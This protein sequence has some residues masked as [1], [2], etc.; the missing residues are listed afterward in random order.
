MPR[1]IGH[2]VWRIFT[3]LLYILVS[4]LTIFF[5]Y[6]YKYDFQKRD[7]QKTSII[8][9]LGEE[10]G[11]NVLLDGVNKAAVLPVQIN[12]VI[13][14]GHDLSVNKT[15]YLPWQRKVAVDADL[16]S[17]IDDVYL[18]PE[19]VEAKI[20][21]VGELDPESK[22]YKG[23]DFLADV[24]EG[25]KS[26]DMMTLFPEGIPKKESID[27]MQDGLRGLQVFEKGD[28]MLFF[29]K[30]QVAIAN[31]GVG[32]FLKF[33]LPSG[34]EEYRLGH[35]NQIFYF[36]MR[37]DLYAVPYGQVDKL[38]SAPKDFLARKNVSAYAISQD[39][40][41]IYISD[42]AVYGC[43]AGCKKTASLGFAANTYEN[44]SVKKGGEYGLLVLRASA[45]RRFMCVFKSGEQI[46]CLTDRLSGGAFLNAYD[47][48][49]YA[50]N[51]GNIYFYDPRIDERKLVASV[52]DGD[53]ELIGWFSNEGH[54]VLKRGGKIYLND[55]N[56]EIGY[57]LLSD[58]S[59]ITSFILLEKALFYLKG[60]SVY[61][62][63]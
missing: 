52:T 53:F 1:K 39:G 38:A 25:G 54:F 12:N 44:L 36:L 10:K 33:T 9:V 59:G 17:I 37:G 20:Q 7:V 27:V 49:L 4:G 41:V 32:R 26:F 6:G 11:V 56:V 55:V 5:A 31:F 42:G 30:G 18:V 47:Q 43:D 34:A 35:D 40:G 15:G 60:S 50:E 22:I 28:F 3:L 29:D 21:K 61:R 45:G 23:D 48:V 58:S 13:P 16:V 46:N 63:L 8:D 24:K 51:N 14:G 2:I 19:G 57:E 62:V